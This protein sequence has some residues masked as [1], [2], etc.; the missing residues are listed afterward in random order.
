MGV[1]MQLFAWQP[2]VTFTGSGRMGGHRILLPT[3]RV[4]LRQKSPLFGL[5]PSL[6][7]VKPSRTA[8]NQSL[9]FAGQ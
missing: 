5:I 4:V 3:N 1:E 6:T 8:A 2:D 7:F 9:I